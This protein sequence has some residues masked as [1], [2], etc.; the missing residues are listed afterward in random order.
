MEGKKEKIGLGGTEAKSDD[1][2]KNVLQAILRE[3]IKYLISKMCKKYLW[4]NKRVR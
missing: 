2:D 4:K 3:L 1:Y